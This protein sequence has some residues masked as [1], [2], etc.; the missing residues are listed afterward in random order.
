MDN[1]NPSPQS[2]YDVFI[3][4]SH[5]DKE[6]V[7]EWL[8]PRLE[9]AGLRACIDFRDFDVA[10]PSRT[11][12]RRAVEASAHTLLVLTQDWVDSDWSGFEALLSGTLD[13][14]NREAKLVP[15]LLKPCRPPIYIAMLTYT[16]FTRE[17][18]W[19]VQLERVL[20]ALRGEL[21]LVA[22][23]RPLDSQPTAAQPLRAVP[24]PYRGLEPF[25]AEH[26]AD[27][28]GREGM[29]ARLVE[30]VKAQPFTAVVGPS[31]CGKS[32]L[33]RAGLVTALTTEDAPTEQPWAIRI[34]RPGA[35]PLRALA[36]ELAALLEPDADRVTRSVQVGTLAEHLATGAQSVADVAASLRELHPDLS[37]VAL[38][39]D[40]F[41]ELYIECKNEALRD[42][43]VEVLLTV[44]EAGL[45]VVLTLRADFFG[46][47]LDDRR[48][49]PQV[50]AGQI[51]MLP[52]NEAELHAAIERPA[53]RAGRAF[54]PGLVEHIL[55][56]ALQ[57]PENLPLLQFALLRLWE[58][59]TPIGT[60]THADYKAIGGVG[61]GI[62]ER[63]EAIYEAL[64]TAGQGE[65]V[66]HILTRLVHYSEENL[67]ARRRTSLN[68]LVTLRFPRER[69]EVVIDRL[70]D[71]R[72]LVTQWEGNK[73]GDV[74]PKS[75]V[76]VAHEALVRSWARLRGWLDED[77]DFGL[78]REKLAVVRQLWEEVEHDDEALLR[79][80]LLVKAQDWLE[81]RE[82]Y[83]AEAERVYIEKS[84]ALRDRVSKSPS[85][86]WAWLRSW[87]FQDR[88]FE[89]WRKKLDSAQQ[90]WVDNACSEAALLHGE[91]LAEAEHWL[92]E[93]GNDLNWAEKMYI[94]ESLKQCEQARKQDVFDVFL[95]YNSQNKPEVKR[96]G[97]RLKEKDI[98]PWLDV[99]EL[100][101]GFAWQRILE[102][103]IAQINAA[104][105]FVGQ[106]GI[107]PWQ[108]MELEGYIREFVRRNCPVIPVILAECDSEPPLPLFLQG[109]T[110][111]DFRERAPDP[112]DQLVWGITGKRNANRHR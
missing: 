41:E 10:V 102:Q 47:V 29:V 91:S 34:F 33:V 38:V 79:G 78:W 92:A 57:E 53:V 107:G 12:M 75:T 111:V 87:L 31:G 11:N 69:L 68:E 52:M 61:G 15:L 80:R 109:V 21:N 101:P 8:L 64:A 88:S 100:R 63:A 35:D 39:A 32:S 89:V 2:Q 1:T 54:E 112:M 105:V 6:W 83:L 74:L 106:E 42:R 48:L 84:L 99:W 66:Q 94:T 103:Q 76:E 9:E 49:G 90:R 20:Q 51:N 14:I 19:D 16:D 70:V 73:S 72:L 36:V 65:V 37:C 18:T 17:D 46:R 40:Q 30:R 13:P 45:K 25:E 43:F 96:I 98:R 28:F 62:V 67:L 22:L 81:E 3:S 5:A 95:C 60:L 59:Q 77:R 104:A 71:A 93:H 50:D 110:W 24:C 27:Y 56:D 26:A 97:D 55:M 7:R 44:L 58:T 82:E 23:G 4:Y 85:L 86:N 108:N